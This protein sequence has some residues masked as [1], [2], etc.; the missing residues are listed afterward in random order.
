[1]NLETHI[2]RWSKGL[3]KGALMIIALISFI[4]IFAAISTSAYQAARINASAGFFLIRFFWYVWP[5]IISLFILS[6]F[7]TKWIKLM[8]V[9]GSGGF[10]AL[11]FATQ[12][13]RAVGGAHRWIFIHGVSMQPSEFLKAFAA[14]FGAMLI[15]RIKH[16][17]TEQ[18]RN[19]WL[20]ILGAFYGLIFLALFMQPDFGTLLIFAAMLGAQALVAGIAWKWIGAG[21]GL[22]AGIMAAAYTLLP[23]IARRIAIFFAPA[24]GDGARRQIDFALDTIRNAGFFGRESSTRAFIP[25]VHTDFVFSAIAEEFG[26]IVALVPVVLFFIFGLAMLHRIR[27]LKNPFNVIAAT[28]IVV[29]LMFQVVVNLMSNLALIPTTGMTLPFISY[30]GS[31][32]VSSAVAVGLL[33]ALIQEYNARPERRHEKE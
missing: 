18:E 6:M 30:G 17:S 3:D 8:A 11:S 23:H 31:S 20:G 29:Y 2:V 27:D 28:G 22:L 14:I 25:D 15:V 19:R 16:A 32:F 24:G 7:S 4:G 10:L 13:F 1:M 9:A 33:L 26:I 21:V 12:A 5:A